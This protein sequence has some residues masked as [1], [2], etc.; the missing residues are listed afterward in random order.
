METFL[1]FLAFG[2]S[3][4]HVFLVTVIVYVFINYRHLCFESKT[5]FIQQTRVEH[6]PCAGSVPST[7]KHQDS[8]YQVGSWAVPVSDPLPEFPRLCS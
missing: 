4:S 8:G 3:L 7:A 5:S 2:A 6:C 1:A